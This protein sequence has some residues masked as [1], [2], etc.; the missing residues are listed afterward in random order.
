MT[1]KRFSIERILLDYNRLLLQTEPAL[2]RE[3]W[4]PTCMSRSGELVNEA[5][6]QLFAVHTYSV[7]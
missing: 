3:R 1:N 5:M 2:L 6:H 7:S 4:Q